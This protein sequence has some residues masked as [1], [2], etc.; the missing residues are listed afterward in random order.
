MVRNHQNIF[1]NLE[2]R[3][4]VKSHLRKIITGSNIEIN[5][6]SDKHLCSA[7]YKRH[8]TKNEKS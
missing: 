5:D 2:E 1:L 6:P 3:N 4:K 7:L 8:S